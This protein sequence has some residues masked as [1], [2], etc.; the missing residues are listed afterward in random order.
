MLKILKFFRNNFFFS[1]QKVNKIDNK[2]TSY[3]K[4]FDFDL[5]ALIMESDKI[6]ELQATK[7]E[8]ILVEMF[9]DG[10]SIELINDVIKLFELKET[11]IK[12]LI[13][14]CLNKVCVSLKGE[15]D[16]TKQDAKWDQSYSKLQGLLDTIS[17]H[18]NQDSKSNEAANSKSK[19][20]SAQTANLAAP[21]IINEEDVME[22]MRTFCNDQQIDINLRLMILEDLKK[23]V[24]NIRDEDLILLL[25][26]K[27]NAILE[28]CDRFEQKVE[29]VDSNDIENESK[30]S[31][32]IDEFIELSNDSKHCLALVNFL[33][34]W[35]EFNSENEQEKPW[36]KVIIKLI[37]SNHPLSSIT[38]E[39]KSKN[40][41][42][43]KDLEFIKSSL[44]SQTDWSDAS[45]RLKLSYLKLCLQLNSV[46]NF[47][48]F[49]ESNELDF[50]DSVNQISKIE[51]FEAILN[52]K[53]LMDLIIEEKR[54]LQIINTSLYFI[55]SK[56]VLKNESKQTLN[57]IAKS[58][59][60]NGYIIE[61]GK[62]FIEAED[63]EESYRTISVS[64][65]F[66]EKL[67]ERN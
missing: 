38:A 3:I 59:R 29:L 21:K 63:L 57:E 67:S 41:I 49:I 34:I 17:N 31:D 56:Y 11:N 24:K 8:S 10:Y 15:S 13:K 1:R 50:L 9:F 18:L 52:D 30:R 4:K 6:A 39:L 7:I 44:Q 22:C 2:S 43:D 16:K 64:L 54:Y 12:K 28:N 19:K 42:K 40:T 36:N 66:I 32:L 62:L 55:F 27:T 5:G 23:S 53:E 60:Q 14:L 61:A 33:K 47:K 25:V 26:A 48:K 46:G 35:P 20:K 51:N 37:L 45:G 58:L 65:K